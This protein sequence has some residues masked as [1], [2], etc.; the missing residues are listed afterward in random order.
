MTFE[1]GQ[2]NQ[3]TG[4]RVFMS[5]EFRLILC[6]NGEM[7]ALTYRELERVPSDL[8]TWKLGIN[9]FVCNL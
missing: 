3:V 7:L 9:S 6:P 8:G 2:I 1:D 4:Y 5:K